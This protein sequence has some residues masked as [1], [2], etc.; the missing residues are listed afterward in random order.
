[1]N[2]LLSIFKT[3][4][5]IFSFSAIFTG[6]HAL[7]IP[8]SFASSFGIPLI[9]PSST[10]NSAE[11]SKLTASAHHDKLFPSDPASAYVSLMGVRQLATGLTLLVF[12]YQGKWTEA[13]TILA[14]LGIVVAGTDGIYLASSGAWSLAKFHAIP[15]A[16]IAALSG[17]IV[18]TMS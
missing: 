16:L 12:A 5:L 4:C 2:L 1:M 13:A 11:E 8:A 18:F 15:G 9:P 3:V 14:I 7:L 6:A 10:V 17:A